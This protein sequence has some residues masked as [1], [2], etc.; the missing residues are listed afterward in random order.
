MVRVEPELVR[1]DGVQQVVLG[2]GES[3]PP[4]AHDP[5]P[6]AVQ[7]Y[8]VRATG[9]GLPWGGRV[10]SERDRALLGIG[11]HGVHEVEYFGDAGRGCWTHRQARLE[12]PAGRGTLRLRLLAARPQPPA[13]VVRLQGGQTVGPLDFGGAPLDVELT[14]AGE[15]GPALVELDSIPY[16]PADEGHGDDRRELGVVLLE[17]HFEPA[18]DVLRRWRLTLD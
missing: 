10:A 9:P 2:R 13:T 16:V 15:H 18:P 5:R 3:Y 1:A 12:V 17:V 6:L 14:V 11:A 4:G 7:L 8:A